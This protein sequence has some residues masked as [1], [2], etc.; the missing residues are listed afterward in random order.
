MQSTQLNKKKVLPEK[1]NLVRVVRTPIGTQ[2]HTFK[3]G[4]DFFINSSNSKVS[5]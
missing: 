4:C 5:L 1:V 2:F 3:V